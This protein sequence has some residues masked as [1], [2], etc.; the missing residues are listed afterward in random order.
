MSSRGRSCH[1]WTNASCVKEEQ[2]EVVI[3]PLDHVRTQRE[4]TVLHLGVDFNQTASLLVP[5]PKSFT[6]TVI[7]KKF[8]GHTSLWHFGIKQD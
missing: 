6:S 7:G 4:D 5:C 8:L 3:H 1:H 2:G